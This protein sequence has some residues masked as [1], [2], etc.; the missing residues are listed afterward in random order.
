MVEGTNVLRIDFA[1]P[2]EKLT[3]VSWEEF[4]RVFDERNLEFLYQDHTHDGHI[5]RFN[6]FVKSGTD[7]EQD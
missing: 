5:S 7:E 2:D 1:E 3:P 4:F 6:K